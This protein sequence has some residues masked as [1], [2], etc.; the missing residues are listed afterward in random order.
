MY[1]RGR[2]AWD[3]GRATPIFQRLINSGKYAPGKM[4]VLGA[5]WGHDAREFARHGFD[6][7]AVDFAAEAADEM[8]KLAEPDA[9]IEILQS[10]IFELPR[11]LDNAFDYCLDYTSFCAIDPARRDE[12]ADLVTRIMKTGGNYIH[13]A[14]PVD[15]HAGGPPFAVDPD[16]VVE[17]FASRGFKLEH[18]ESPSDSV[19]GRRGKEEL[20]IFKK[21]DIV[22]ASGL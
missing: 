5:G 12:Y 17:L 19:R 22:T 11:T 13:L 3:L 18:H 21:N 6:V 2:A 4:I 15:E 20:L 14:F 16:Q 9:P 1:Q 10:D 7:T 8:R